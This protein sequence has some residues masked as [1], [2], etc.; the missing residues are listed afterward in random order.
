M[1]LYLDDLPGIPDLPGAKCKGTDGELFYPR[2][3][4]ANL[5]SPDVA[6]AFAVCAGC[7]AKTAC[8]AWALEHRENGIWGGTTER[9]RRIMLRG[10]VA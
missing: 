2:T 6:A 7:P 5:Q 10:D 3:G 1:S 9:Q 4:L 8:L